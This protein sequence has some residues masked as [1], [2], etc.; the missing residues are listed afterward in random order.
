[1]VCLNWKSLPD[2]FSVIETKCS[3]SGETQSSRR[4]TAAVAAKNLKFK[5]GCIIMQAMQIV[6]GI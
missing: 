6:A 3:F 1:M 5:C 2:E 4:H